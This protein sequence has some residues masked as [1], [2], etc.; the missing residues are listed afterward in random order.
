MKCPYCGFPESKVVD[1]RPS[2]AAIRRRRE[3]FGC[4]KRF[5]TYEVVER[6]PTVV[7]KRDGSRQPFDRMKLLNSM[8]RACDKRQVP[9]SAL[10]NAAIAIET[11]LQ[12]SPEREIPSQRVGEK[13][14]RKLRDLD[15]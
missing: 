9:L 7:I 6:T 14:M 8:L 12:A 4:M 3:C 1:S 5:T 13:V 10:E 2:E 11:E 15:E